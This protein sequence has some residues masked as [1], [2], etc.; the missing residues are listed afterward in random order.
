MTLEEGKVR[1]GDV[2]GYDSGKNASTTQYTDEIIK[3]FG[4]TSTKWKVREYKPIKMPE[5]SA[6]PDYV[7]VTSRRVVGV[8]YFLESS[9]FPEPLGKS[10]DAI[11]EG[12][13]FKVKMCSSRGTKVYPP[14][15]TVIDVNDQY[16]CRMMLRDEKGSA[17][18]EQIIA[19][20]QKISTVHKWSHLE[21]LHEFDGQPGFTKAQG[22]D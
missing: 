12:S 11:A 22:E 8:D 10:L 6:A 2:V 3:N 16:R 5:I 19:M 1:T 7:K 20:L 17:T 21:K 14:T 13:P 15:G 4:K 9:L 18:D